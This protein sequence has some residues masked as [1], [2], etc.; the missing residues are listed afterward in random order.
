MENNTDNIIYHNKSMHLPHGCKSSNETTRNISTGYTSQ[1][2]AT[3]DGRYEWCRS[4]LIK[5]WSLTC[6][7]STAT[8]ARNENYSKPR[9]LVTNHMLS[10]YL[11]PHA[12]LLKLWRTFPW[13]WLRWLSRPGVHG[14]SRPLKRPCHFTYIRLLWHAVWTTIFAMV[15][16]LG[17]FLEIRKK[18]TATA[19]SSSDTCIYSKILPHSITC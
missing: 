17:L 4:Y 19:H 18:K 16:I 9:L 6:S 1:T 15:I 14:W 5:C 13:L 2:D 12:A 11:T 3:T 10:F 7:N 8:A